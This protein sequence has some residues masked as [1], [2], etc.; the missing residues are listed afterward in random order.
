MNDREWEELKERAEKTGVRG[1]IAADMLMQAVD[2]ASTFLDPVE[3][4]DLL[5]LVTVIWQQR[6]ESAMIA[7]D[8]AAVS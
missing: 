5:L 2:F 6:V 8:H 1:S 7:N 3:V 4:G